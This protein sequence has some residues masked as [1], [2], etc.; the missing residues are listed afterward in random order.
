MGKNQRTVHLR[1]RK[2]CTG[3]DRHDL[4]G[5]VGGKKKGKKHFSWEVRT[6]TNGSKINYK[7]EQVG[8]SGKRGLCC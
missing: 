2:K 4:W 1:R 6:E 3:A 5:G 7:V 8:V